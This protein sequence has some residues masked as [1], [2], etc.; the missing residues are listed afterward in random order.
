[1]RTA[2][3]LTPEMH[4]VVA[5]GQLLF[6]RKW[7]APTARVLDAHPSTLL[8]WARG[9]GYPGQTDVLRMLGELR[10]HYKAVQQVH[11]DALKTLRLTP[12][13]V[14]SIPPPQ[15]GLDLSV[16]NLGPEP[17]YRHPAA[18]APRRPNGT[19]MPGPRGPTPVPPHKP[20]WQFDKR[21][22][23]PG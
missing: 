17:I 15:R 4:A 21:S 10:E 7:K 2:R 9:Q 8:R 5:I 11:N 22:R 19:L 3:S 12:E 1:M 23:R 6:G 16:F 20:S 13:P 14:P 18:T